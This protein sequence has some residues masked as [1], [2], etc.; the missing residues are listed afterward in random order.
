MGW[1]DGSKWKGGHRAER[2]IRRLPFGSAMV[3][4]GVTTLLGPMLP[5]SGLLIGFCILML[6]TLRWETSKTFFKT[7]H[8]IGYFAVGHDCSV[9]SWLEDYQ[10]L[11]NVLVS[12]RRETRSLD[13]A[14][15]TT[16]VRVC[17]SIEKERCWP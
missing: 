11:R 14:D 8:V 16:H 3:W 10:T 13:Y 17:W 6:F 12:Q 2:T 7:A 9:G 5:S 1:K 15:R 4:F